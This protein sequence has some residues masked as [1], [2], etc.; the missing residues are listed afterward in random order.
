MPYEPLLPCPFCGS[1]AEVGV[2]EEGDNMDAA[3]VQCTS[4][5]A[6]SR[7]HFPMKED[8]KPHVISAW[9]RRVGDI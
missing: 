1:R 4:C 2:I 7:L 9:N 5:A 8:P 6:S 3:Y